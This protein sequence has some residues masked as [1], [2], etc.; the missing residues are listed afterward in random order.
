MLLAEE[1]G[2]EEF[3]HRVKIYATDIDESAL[4][5]ARLGVYTL[6]DLAA[7]PEELRDKYFEIQGTRGTFPADLRRSVIFGRHDLLQD[8]PISRLDLL[9]C[10]NTLMYF[11]ADTQSRILARLHYALNDGG[12]LFAGRAEMLLSHANLFAPGDLKYRIFAR[13]ATAGFR[14]RLR[15]LAQGGVDAFGNHVG[16]QVRLREAALD[17]GGSAAIVIDTEGVLVMANEMA[18]TSL[19]VNTRDLGRRLQD[20]EI[21][22]RPAELRAVVEQAINERRTIQLAGVE[23]IDPT[24]GVQFYDVA[25]TPLVDE[26]GDALGVVIA[27]KDV[28]TLSRLRIEL[29]R[30]RQ[31]LETAYEELQ[32][33]NE[34]LETTNEELQST[35][36]ELETT[37]EELQSANEE[38]ETMNEELQSTNGELESI[39]TELSRRS[40]DVV[41]L[42]S[43]VESVLASLEVGVAVLDSDLRVVVWNERS[44]DLWGLREWEVVGQ[45]FMAL[46]IGL[47]VDELAL[48]IRR[49]LTGETENHRVLEALTRRGRT[50]ACRVSCS[51]VRA[52]SGN[53]QGVVVLMEE[54]GAPVELVAD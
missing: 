2:V 52:P 36:E 26:D 39:N 29:A 42:N 35:V 5:R 14:T 21:S 4:A 11:T 7:V 13:V 49:C 54:I 48:P 37:N 32:S 15:M 20:A 44:A 27:F 47:P 40:D 3:K 19:G 23:R 24:D 22:Y 41:R 16:R 50:I 10:R 18:R 31:E 28:T 8:A 34:E 51:P 9:V 1:V 45:P 12:Y 25:V 6:K 46:D 53:G 43:F 38:L 30:S 33:T 17:A